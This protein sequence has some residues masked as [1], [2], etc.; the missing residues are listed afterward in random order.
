[1]AKGLCNKHYLERYRQNPDYKKKMKEY[2][3]RWFQE[4]KDLQNMKL[5]REQRYFEGKREEVLER[6]GYKCTECN[7]S[8]R[9][10]VHHKD[11]SG[12]GY[13]SETNNDLDNL[14]TLCKACHLEIHRPEFN[15]NAFQKI[16]LWSKKYLCCI[17]CGTKERKYGGL[18]M[19]V[20]CYARFRNSQKS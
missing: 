8:S 2:Q 19:C 18:G 1:M 3:A 20:N 4:N 12:R 17:D 11:G 14:V 9:L 13:K 10:V 7:A 5:K 15:R 16:G 6:D